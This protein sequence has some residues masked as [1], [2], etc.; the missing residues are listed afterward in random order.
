ML[1]FNFYNPTQL[2]FGSNRL[3]ELDQ[4]VPTNAKV[5]ITYGGQSAKKFGT[6]DKVRDSLGDRDIIEFGGIEANPKYETLIEATEVVKR[7]DIDFLLAVGGGSVMDGT[8][9]IALAAMHGTENY[10]GILQHGFA[11]VPVTDALPVGCVVTLPATGSEANAFGVVTVNGH[12][13]PFMSPLV[14]PVFS[15]LDPELTLTLPS[16][17]ISNG[18][19]DAFVHVVEYYLTYPVNAKVQDRIAEGV[20][21]TLIEDGPVTYQDNSDIEARQNFI[22]SAT[23]ALNGS[24]G[25]GTPGDFATHMIGHELTGLFGIDHGRTLAIVLPSLLRE[26]KDKKRE[27]LLQFAER[28]WDIN[29]GSDDEKIDLAIDKTEAFFQSMDVPTKL[30]DYEIDDEGIEQVVTNLEKLG[31]TALSE[32]GDLTLDIV[33]KILIAAK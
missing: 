13:A 11:P 20:L 10:A 8:K 3:A 28:V 9:Y 12:K 27:K 18:V 25:A 33:R 21:K 23:T 7:E 4:L 6:I 30:S 31:M 22:W 26:R 2:V 14:F 15:F 16:K 17:Q 29:E 1:D 24:I 19:T 32:T 5:M